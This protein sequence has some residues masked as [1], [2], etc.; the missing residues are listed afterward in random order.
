MKNRVDDVYVVVARL[1]GNGAQPGDEDVKTEAGR[2]I[3]TAQYEASL[4]GS[5]A[6]VFKRDELQNGRRILLGGISHFMQQM[7]SI[8]LLAYC[9][10]L[11]LPRVSRLRLNPWQLLPDA[12]IIFENSL[13]LGGKLSIVLSGVG[14]T[15]FALGTFVSIFFI[16]RVGRRKVRGVWILNP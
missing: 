11:S 16:E 13:G 8:N 5:W 2:I 4:A 10:F 12:P 14:A 3:E 9:E 7:A 6:E 15:S 1:K